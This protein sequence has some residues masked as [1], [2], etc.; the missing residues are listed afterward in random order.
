MERQ[1]GQDKYEPIIL[2]LAKTQEARHPRSVFALF[3]MS[4][5][6]LGAIGG[7]GAWYL[8]THPPNDSRGGNPPVV[9]AKASP[10][11]AKAATPIPTATPAAQPTATPTAAPPRQ[12]KTTPAPATTTPVPT[13]IPVAKGRLT[14]NSAPSNAEVKLNG[15]TIGRTPLTGYELEPGN[16]PVIF[17][18]DGQTHQQTL[19]VAAGEITEYTHRF[20][21]FGALKIDTTS[22]G[23]DVMVN[24][25]F[26]GK[27]PVSVEGL[28][29]GTY[30]IVIKK[31]GFRTVEETVTLGQ[32]E[33]RDLFIT[34]KRLSSPSD[35]SAPIFTPDRPLHPS[36][37]QQ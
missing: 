35:N 27:S 4:V 36:E 19:R 37:R 30:T 6:L 9:T 14:L 32:G 18:F 31:T 21:G 12:A 33:V 23:C 2:N 26:Y 29:A 5:A 1:N 28:P 22:S 3:V 20:E 11:P 34:V 13:P 10:A 25:N 8:R 24:G 7:F 17:V 15:N 16:Y